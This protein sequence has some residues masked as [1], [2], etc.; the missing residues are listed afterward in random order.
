VFAAVSHTENRICRCQTLP[1]LGPTA[2][3]QGAN[4]TARVAAGLLPV[5]ST[6]S[7]S[8]MMSRNSALFGRGSLSALQSRWCQTP[9][10]PEHV[11]FPLGSS[12]ESMK[13]FHGT[14]GRTSAMRMLRRVAFAV[15]NTP[16]LVLVF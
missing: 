9:V 15:R 6:A 16:Q 2:L 13:A 5:P 7:A 1:N 12:S 11:D 4:F 8:L 3:K 10:F 14:S